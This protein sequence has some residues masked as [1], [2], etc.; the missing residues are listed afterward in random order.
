MFVFKCM[1]C[2]LIDSDESKFRQEDCEKCKRI[3]Y[4]CYRCGFQV[5]K[6]MTPND[7]IEN[8]K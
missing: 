7:Q 4:Y 6:I 3:K 1:G 2:G 8:K 5:R